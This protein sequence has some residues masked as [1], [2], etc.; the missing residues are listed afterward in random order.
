LRYFV[1]IAYNGNAY[2]GWQK[3]PEHI[4]VQGV[5]EAALATAL[6]QKIETVGAGRTDTGVH[7]KQFF[8]H[9]DVEK[10]ISDTGNL[11]YKLNT[12]L[13]ADIAVRSIFKVSKKTH[14][15]FDATLREYTYYVNTKKDPFREHSAY[16]V[17]KKIDMDLM[18]QAAK[19]LLNYTDFQTFSKVK[20]DVKTYNCKLEYAFWERQGDEL[21]FKI[22]ADRF[23]RNMVRAIVGT[24]LEIGT[25]KTEL[26]KMEKIIESKKRGKAGKSVPAHALFLTR[27]EYDFD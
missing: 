1:E 19:V 24:L 21:V 27:V 8:A 7:A 2:H 10:K 4:T 25:G 12:I 11:V 13:P 15:R 6:Q 26:K 23:L 3:Q 16:Y 9:F 17:K 20:T 14:A 5:L 22:R 18:N